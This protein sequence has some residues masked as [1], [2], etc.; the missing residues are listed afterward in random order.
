MVLPPS[1]RRFVRPLLGA[2]ALAGVLALG[3]W[4]YRIVAHW[5]E[6]GFRRTLPAGASDVHEAAWEEG[7]L[8][9]YQYCLKARMTAEEFAAYAKKHDLTPATPGRVYEDAEDWSGLDCPSEAGATSWWNPPKGRDGWLI[10]QAG[11]TWTTAVFHD[12]Y[13]Y[14]SSVN[15]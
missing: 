7:F 8:P 12:G 6:W 10:A 14:L 5:N 13:L 3:V 1:L 9:D 11:H 2:M 15:H 4:A